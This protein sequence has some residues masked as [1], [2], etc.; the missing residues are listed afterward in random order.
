[1][2]WHIRAEDEAAGSS[3]AH[4]KGV[5]WPRVCKLQSGVVR[6]TSR[7]TVTTCFA[8]STGRAKRSSLEAEPEADDR[9]CEPSRPPLEID[10]A[11]QFY[12]FESALFAQDLDKLLLLRSCLGVAIKIH[13]IVEIARPCAFGQR[14]EFFSERFDVII[15]K[16]L[17]AFSGASVHPA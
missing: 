13:Y 9:A 7:S 4:T 15:G 1:V 11:R 14:G 8:Q 17:D 5:S 2:L 3:S 16:D 12:A 6:K 10:K